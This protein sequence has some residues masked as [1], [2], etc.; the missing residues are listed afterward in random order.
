VGW[1]NRAETGSCPNGSRARRSVHVVRSGHCARGLLLEEGEKSDPGVSILLRPT[2]R[3]FATV[4]WSYV[5]VTDQVTL[6]AQSLHQAPDPRT[7]SET[8]PGLDNLVHTLPF[9]AG[10]PEVTSLLLRQVALRHVDQDAFST[11]PVRESSRQSKLTAGS[12]RHVRVRSKLRSNRP[13]E[14]TAGLRRG[15]MMPLAAE[16]ASPPGGG[17]LASEPGA[18]ALRVRR[19]GLQFPRGAG[20]RKEDQG[21]PRFSR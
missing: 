16:A 19:I 10:H 18:F 12:S 13:P 15:R 1:C 3:S 9:G 17:W 20:S 14:G 11:L 8:A 21:E 2:R 5:S 6:E 4:A 7:R